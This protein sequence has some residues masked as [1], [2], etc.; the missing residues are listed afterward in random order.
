MK[1]T[2]TLG[3]L[4][5]AAVL[6]AGCDSRPAKPRL[7]E[8]ERLPRVETL[9]PEYAHRQVTIDTLAT[10]EPME[11]ARLSAQVQGEVKGLTPDIDIGRRIHK[12]E[13]LITLD[14]PAALA[15][16]ESKKALLVQARGLRDQAEEARKVAI[17]DVEEAVAQVV[18]WKADLSFK[19]VQLKRVEELVAK[20]TLQPILKEESELQRDTARAALEAAQATVNTK[21]AKLKSAEVE[22]KVAETRIAVAQADVKVADTKV[23][24]AK[25]RAPFDGVITR[26]WVD[27]G[28]IIKDPSQ[29]LLTVMRT[30]WV[31]VMIDIPEKYAPLIRAKESQSATGEANWVTLT[32]GDHQEKEQIT[33]QAAAID[34]QTRLLRAE[35]HLR[36]DSN[37]ALRPGATGTAII[38][39]DDGKKSRLNIPSTALV[40]V[41]DQIRVYYVDDLSKDNPPRG[42]VKMHEVQ[43][44]LDDGKTVEITSGLPKDALVIAKGNGVVRQG[45]NVLAVPALPQRTYR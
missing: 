34:A 29:P 33:R 8:V 22:L 5:V 25:I 36:N 16:Q 32:I 38:V 30:D 18:R 12:D 42:V 21:R 44:G 43:I 6:G 23:E 45:E 27:N 7:G 40:R 2:N 9:K 10:V 28:A 11:R 31:R 14:I 26:R 37:L 1:V 17:R 15:E 39:L 24:F 20:G 41:G 4:A 3:A 19:E 13:V 35:V